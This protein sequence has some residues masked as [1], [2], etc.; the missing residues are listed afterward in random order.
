MTDG[1]RG[2]GRRMARLGVALVAV[3]LVAGLA[4]Y[5]FGRTDPRRA[6]ALV[7]RNFAQ[8][9]PVGTATEGAAPTSGSAAADPRC[10][11]TDERLPPESQIG[12]LRAGMVIV[13][14]RTDE[15]APSLLQW[16]GD[17]LRQVLVAPNEDL[18]SPIVATAWGRRMP[19][20]EPNTELLTAFVTAYGG[21]GPD[22]A[23]CQTQG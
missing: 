16:A 20:E 9:E 23:S 7:V 5:L 19:L 12:T 18:D 6:A 17:H 22:S 14:Y 10:G 2:L 8:A 3:A 1:E 21:Q 11:V 13:Q 4:G 15:P